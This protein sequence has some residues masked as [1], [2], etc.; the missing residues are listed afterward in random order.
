VL[1]QRKLS[2]HWIKM[3]HLNYPYVSKWNCEI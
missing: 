1:T 2:K 3:D